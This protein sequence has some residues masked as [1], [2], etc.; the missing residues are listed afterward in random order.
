[1]NQQ[2]IPPKKYWPYDEVSAARDVSIPGRYILSSPWF[3][4]HIDID[5]NHIEKTN[6]IVKKLSSNTLEPNDFP[7]VNWF[8]SALSKYPLAY[9]LPRTHYFGT[10]IHQCLK[11]PIHFQCPQ[12]Y[13]M[14]N[15]NSGAFL[16]EVQKGMLKDLIPLSWNWDIDAALAFSKT[17]GGFDPESLFSVARRF[18]LLNDLENNK[19]KELL[20]YT[21]SLKQQP[22]KFRKA[23]ALIARQN[24][25]ITE[26]CDQTLRT[27]LPISQKAQD[28]V[29]DFIQAE[30]GH[31]KIIK[32][33]LN[34]LGFEPNEI[35]VLNSTMTL[36]EIFKS[37]ASKN[38]LAF[39]FIT[40]IFERTSYTQEDP[41]STT[42]KEGGESIAAHQM[43][44][45]RDINDEGE[46]ENV[47]LSFLQFMSPVDQDYA[48]E[49]LRWAELATLVA[50]QISAE[51][52]RELKK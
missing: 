33:A 24:H 39:A 12:E 23:S 11:S 6:H 22:E 50:H 32:K 30:S 18:H 38:F 2:N 52:L 5:P 31:D 13:L 40:D 36:M 1:M 21:T 34:S 37:A 28:E 25:F 3:T 43:N 20:E 10:D 16:T 41:F 19:T 45:H 9:I 35:P 46:H 17:D 4:F 7:D 49:A 8:F 47:A 15:V 14:K 27:A 51:T 29:L 42:L 44:V 48:T 26:V